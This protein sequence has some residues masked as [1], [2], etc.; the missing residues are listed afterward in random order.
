MQENGTIWA[1]FR[2]IQGEY[3]WEQSLSGPMN[4]RSYTWAIRM[5]IFYES[6]ELPQCYELV[7]DRMGASVT[8]SMKEDEF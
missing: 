4:E 6:E 1:G 7:S 5:D 8:G 3:I 2:Q